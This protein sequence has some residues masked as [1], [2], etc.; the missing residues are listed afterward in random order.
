[1]AR[2]GSQQC[3]SLAQ[4]SEWLRRKHGFEAKFYTKV[5]CYDL[6]PGMNTLKLTRFR[7]KIMSVKYI[8]QRAKDTQRSIVDDVCV[9]PSCVA[10]GLVQTMRN[11]VQHHKI[12]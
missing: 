2:V 4:L 10:Q 6:K 1:M 12:V 5:F 8:R 7:L 9:N 3:S 11:R